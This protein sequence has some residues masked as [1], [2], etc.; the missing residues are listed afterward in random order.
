[1][2][3][4][5]I[6]TPFP[7]VS[8]DASYNSY[9]L[10][11]F[12]TNYRGKELLHHG[13]VYFGF[14]SMV[15]WMPKEKTGIAVFANMNGTPLTYILTSCIYDILLDMKKIDHSG[16]FR[17]RYGRMKAYY[18]KYESAV[19]RNRVP[20]T[21]PTHTLDEYTGFYEESGYGRFEIIREG[22]SLK[23][24]MSLVECPVSHY[25]Y[26]VFKIINPEDKKE[27]LLKFI[28][29]SRGEISGFYTKFEPKTSELFFGKVT[30][31]KL[32]DIS[33]LTQFEGNYK[34][35]KNNFKVYLNENRLCIKSLRIP[36][37]ALSPYKENFFDF[38]SPSPYMQSFSVEFLSEEKAGITGAKLINPFEIE[39]AEKVN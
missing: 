6:V 39:K 8:T 34:S 21:N 35:E 38:D 18:K 32:E 13:G 1:M 14:S 12:V 9:G 24:I 17:Q 36:E 29:G 26:D 11:I 23:A 20:G 5:Q 15:S 25:H 22:D 16:P 37:T 27:F 7:P 28:T 2:R 30:N 4:P 33:Y 31:P 10:G 3:K 19:D